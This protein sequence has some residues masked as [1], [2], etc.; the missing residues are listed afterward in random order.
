MDVSIL[1]CTHNSNAKLGRC[2]QHLANQKTGGKVSWEILICDYISDDGTAETVQYYAENY[3]NLKFNFIQVKEAG[4]TPA[5]LAGFNAAKGEAV[6]IVDDDNFVDESYVEVACK[7]I[8]QHSDIG[9]IGAFGSP[10]FEDCSKVPSW[11]KSFEGVYAVGHQ[12]SRKGYIHGERYFFW[13][14][15]SVFRKSAFLRAIENGFTPLLNPSRGTGGYSFMPG[16]TGGE[17]PEMCFAILL[18]G[19][20]L[21][22]EPDLKYKHQIPSTRLTKKFIY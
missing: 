7:L 12:F 10:L 9:V 3:P 1:I 20:K 14:A 22:Y 4:K 13:G 5:L 15:G 19:Y 2:L 21:W 17:D 18:A 6:C 11:F 8:S 16:F